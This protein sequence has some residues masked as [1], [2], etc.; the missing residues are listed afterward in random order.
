MVMPYEKYK[1]KPVVDVFLYRGGDVAGA[2]IDSLFAVLGLS[3]AWVAMSTAPLA[4]VWIAL[5]AGLGAAR[6]KKLRKG[7]PAST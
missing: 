6:S 4:G 1:A 3:I 5:S 7:A 2:G